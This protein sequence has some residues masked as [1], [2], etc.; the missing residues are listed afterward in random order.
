[1]FKEILISIDELETRVAVLE[2]GALMEIYIAREE[3]QIG[4]IYKGKV[5]NILP[6]MQAAFVDIGLERNAFL[7]MDDASA[8]LGEEEPPDIKQL[9]IKDILKLNQETLVQ[10]VKESMGTKGARVT[11]YI[12]LPGRYLVFL[13]KAQYIGISR[14]IEDEKE[15]ERL[16]HLAE[17]I[18]PQ[19]FGLIVRTAAEGRDVEDLRRDME[20]LIKLWEK[21][22][23]SAKRKRAPAIIHQELTLVYKIIRDLFTPEVDR[24]IIDSKSEFDKVSEL[25]D[26]ISPKLK[27]RMHLFSDKRSLFEAYGIE[28]E[29]DKALRRKVWLESGGYLIIDKTEALTVIDVNTGK[30]IG[31][32]SLA[33]TIL[34][35]NLEAVPE[36]VRQI[37]LRDLGGIIIIDFIDMDRQEDKQKVLTELADRLK[38]DRT[39][40]HLVG[41]TELGL[42]QITRKRVSKDLDE[43]L[44]ETCPYCGGK[45]RVN[46]LC[47][48][49][50]KVEREIKK[51]SSDSQYE[52]ILVEITPRLAI[53]I[54]GWEGEDLERLEQS[55]GKTIYLIAN[56]DFHIEKTRI[57]GMTDRK[58]EECSVSIQSGDEIELTIQDIFGSNFQN[59]MG[60]Y[61]NCIVEIL[62]GGNRVGEAIRAVVTS[63][64][65]NYVQ[66][67]IKE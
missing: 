50:I 35:T 30:F 1:M 49:R 38:R 3:R 16:K 42:V 25:L 66:A 36:I 9:S 45:G 59:G 27:S 46:S 8:M 60:V 34:K 43:Y 53:E 39:K 11:T 26:I 12:T 40:T 32:T 51:I 6:G 22:Q 61:R 14:R 44:R 33:E 17:S 63:T 54:L 56:P 29:I 52:S 62:M 19:E 15:R 2:D 65:H 24:L 48:M 21:I 55:T 47:T 10:I 5:A 67:H 20:F 13:P 37:R 41:L 64:H 57:E 28:V 18:K 31:K 4:S 23:N 7:C 58:R